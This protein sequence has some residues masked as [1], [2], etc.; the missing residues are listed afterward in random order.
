MNQLLD[1][2]LRHGA[3]VVFLFTLAGRVGAPVPTAPLLIVAGGL[4]A[5]GE[6]ATSYVFGAATVASTIGDFVWYLAGR[7]YGHRV[8]R[9]L[10]RISL[11]PDSCVRQS[12]TLIARWGGVSIVGAKF[13]PG[14][15]VVAAPMAGAFAM[16]VWKFLA[17][18]LLAAIVWSVTFLGVG[19]LFRTQITELLDL[20]S[21][22][23]TW[24]LA[25]LVFAVIAFV[26][27]RYWRRRSFQREVDLPRIS[28]DDLRSRLGD[29]LPP[30]VVDVRSSAGRQIDARRIPGA[31]SFQ[32]NEIV[33][34]SSALPR[35]RDIVV[36][37]NCPNDVS[38]AH[39][40]RLLI[41][42]GFASV[43]P[44]AGGLDAWIASGGALVSIG[45]PTVAAREAARSFS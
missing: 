40:A 8:M 37:C 17:F 18:D 14:V 28:A 6:L 5:S 42:S 29:T 35:D 36:F 15:S 10:C 20:M 3:L 31:L 22:A 9:A 19:F 16:P 38:A 27:H 41:E 4:A 26:A 43:R 34:Q 45:P 24:A 1:L 23:G 13:L 11:S 21:T 25:A 32:M 7:R 30:I 12:E 33:A 2:L 39:A 44:L